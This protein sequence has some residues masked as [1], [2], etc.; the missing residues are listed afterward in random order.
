M[1]S[2]PKEFAEK[3]R[4]KQQELWETVSA[5]PEDALKRNVVLP[6]RNYVEDSGSISYI[7]PKQLI[8]QGKV[9]HVGTKDIQEGVREKLE[10]ADAEYIKHGS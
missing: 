7:V 2:R 6:Y 9:R 3:M 8:T 5:R 1:D 10:K 4:N